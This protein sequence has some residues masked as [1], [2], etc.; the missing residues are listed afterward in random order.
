MIVLGENIVA[1]NL[2]ANL[3][4]SASHSY[5]EE[6]NINFGKKKDL[7]RQ[8]LKNKLEVF[9]YIKNYIKSVFFL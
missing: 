6:Q 9:V 2:S 8:D 1:G 4:A 5:F 3:F 7:K